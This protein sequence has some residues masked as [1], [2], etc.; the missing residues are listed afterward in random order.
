[1]LYQHTASTIIFWERCGWPIFGVYRC[2]TR[3]YACERC[4]SVSEMS[5]SA[6]CNND[7]ITVLYIWHVV[8]VQNTHTHR[9]ITSFFFGKYLSLDL[10]LIWWGHVIV[11]NIK[12]LIHSIKKIRN[13]NRYHNCIDFCVS[14]EKCERLQ[15]NYIDKSISNTWIRLYVHCTH[16][17]IQA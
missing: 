10:D 15:G 9:Q 12:V 8:V 5:P 7:N 17:Y 3:I 6:L 4:V 16:V 1:M 14:L 11:Y 13:K 2:T